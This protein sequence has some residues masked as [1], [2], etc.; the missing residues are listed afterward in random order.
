MFVRKQMLARATIATLLLLTLPGCNSAKGPAEQ[1]APVQKQQGLVQ[2]EQGSA[3]DP[4]QK[5]NGTVITRGDVNRAVKALLAQNQVPEPATPEVMQQANQAALSQLVS[6]ELVYQAAGKASI[7]DLDQQVAQKVAQNRASQKDEAAF[8]KTLQDAGLT[9]QAFQELVRKDIV[10]NSFIE[11]QFG[12]KAT[13]SEAEAKKFYSDNR[14]KFKLGDMVRA[15]HILIGTSE[16]GGVQE[17]KSARE[18]AV[19]LLQRVKDGE[20][21]GMMAKTYSTC[22]SKAR[23]GDLGAFGQGQ[24]DPAFE[25]AAFSLKPGAISDIVETP[26]GFHIIKVKEKQPARTE[27][28]ETAKARIQQYLKKE[29]MLKMLSDYVAELRSKARIE[30]VTGS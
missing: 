13:V 7:K 1:L 5:V 20:D 23:G 3:A 8:Q 4:V 25:K 21:F 24:M 9:L 14:E 22:P 2:G 29:R 15:S 6:A 18:K 10:I 27:S 16:K 30:K 28:Y 19:A 11:K 26:F 17:R 12:S